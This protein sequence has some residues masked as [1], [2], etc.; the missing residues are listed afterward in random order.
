MAGI[1]HATLVIEATEKSGTLITARLT[2]EYNRELLI[3][4][5]NIFSDSSKGNHQFLKLGAVPITT[6]SAPRAIAFAT[7]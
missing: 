3:V 7:S 5:G 4:P 1:S 2:T 6:P